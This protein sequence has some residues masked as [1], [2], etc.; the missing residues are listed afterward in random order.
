MNKPFD[1]DSRIFFETFIIEQGLEEWVLGY[2]VPGIPDVVIDYLIWDYMFEIRF[3]DYHNPTEIA[4]FTHEP[5]GENVNFIMQP[6]NID[7]YIKKYSSLINPGLL[8]GNLQKLLNEGS[9]NY[10][11]SLLF[12]TFD[13]NFEYLYDAFVDLIKQH[14]IFKE[15]VR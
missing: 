15:F 10:N 13:F 5:G 7:E 12:I 11:G 8:T 6:R 14:F 3:G 9:N 4:S 2:K 1:Y